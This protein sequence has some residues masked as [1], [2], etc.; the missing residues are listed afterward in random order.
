MPLPRLVHCTASK[1]ELRDREPRN[2]LE[3]S[4]D[5]LKVYDVRDMEDNNYH[6]MMSYFLCTTGSNNSAEGGPN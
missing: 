3:Y 2:L 6:D 5:S 1:C 4:L